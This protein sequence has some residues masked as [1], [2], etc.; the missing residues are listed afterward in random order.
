MRISLKR[1][2]QEGNVFLIVMVSTGILSVI[3]LGS[4]LTLASTEHRTV[5]RS[6]AWNTA[7]PLAEAGVE[8]TLSHIT[9]NTNNF[10]ADGWSLVGTNT[11]AKARTNLSTGSYNVRFT[12][13]VGGTVTITSTGRALVLNT[14]Y[15]SRTVQVVAQSGSTLPRLTGLVAKNGIGTGGDFGVDSYD[16]ADPTFS[17]NGRYDPAKA[18]DQASVST[19]AGFNMGGHSHIYGFVHT[20]PGFTVSTG[21]GA[22][23]GDRAWVDARRKG[24]QSSPTNH[25]AADF[26]S[27]IPDVTAPFTSGTAPAAGAVGGQNYN[28]VLN[29]GNYMATSLNA[30]GGNTTMVV[31][32]PS[33]LVVDGP[34][35]LSKIVFAPGASIDLFI[36]TPSI[37]FCPSI[38]CT[39][40]TQPVTPIQ[41]RTWGLPTCTS[42]D[43]TGGDSFTGVIYAP[44]ANLQARGN[45]AFYGAVTAASFNCNG[46]F[47]MHY[48][49]ATARYT[50]P[51]TSFTV[52]SWLEL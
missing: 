39:D 42:M 8:E 24:I 35:S 38:A 4:Y 1:A 26:T 45:A 50:P 40:P 3:C 46:T 21:G 28:Y 43:M 51:T 16:S 31:T 11:Y 15:I 6:Q 30:G 23:V 27:P 18:S 9:R 14:N 2:G 32:A 10:A 36:A 44:E 37:S 17:T 34:I 20:A 7:M 25:F 41:F 48:D 49:L 19:P 22:T 13:T 33:V 52:L 12:G 5:M 47:D 29:G